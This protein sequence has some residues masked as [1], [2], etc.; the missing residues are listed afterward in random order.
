MKTALTLLP[1]VA[2]L[3]LASPARAMD[4]NGLYAIY[5]EAECKDFL[6]ARQDDEDDDY[7]W[8]ITGWLTGVNFHAAKTYDLLSVD[9]SPRDVLTW[10]DDYCHKHTEESLADGL[11]W[12]YRGLHPSR[13]QHAPS[14]SPG[15]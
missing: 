13:R 3:C 8:W 4:A 7:E 1:L 11:V 2:L 15:Q 5:G 6:K 12:L 10:L 14:Q 9:T